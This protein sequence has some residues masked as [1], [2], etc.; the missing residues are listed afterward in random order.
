MF[1]A[2]NAG[3][4]PQKNIYIADDKRDK[5]Q[6]HQG[7]I[8]KNGQQMAFR[9]LKCSVGDLS[10]DDNQIKETDEAK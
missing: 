2:E 9:P 6:W 7:Q 3:V 10:N 8:A 5:R 1:T 4:L